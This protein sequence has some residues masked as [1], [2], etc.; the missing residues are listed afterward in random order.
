MPTYELANP[1]AIGDINTTFNE[2]NQLVAVDKA[3][4]A[5][6]EHAVNITNPFV[7]TMRNI[8]SNKLYNFVINEKINK[9][10]DVKYTISKIG[11]SM[12]GSSLQS[13][14]DS[15]NETMYGG[16]K[17]S[18]TSS[19]SSDTTVDMYAPKHNKYRRREDEFVYSPFTPS[20]GNI[21]LVYNLGHL[22]NIPNLGM[23]LGTGI[24]YPIPLFGI[25]N[26]IGN[27]HVFFAMQ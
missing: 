5:I 26:L 13:F 1:K 10:M 2:K 7:I 6:S 8:K 21:N 11:N 12:P 9:E 25:P 18:D 24:N 23:L 4:Q 22:S 27:G 14:E 20:H 15:I 17:S 3:W 19:S 16:K